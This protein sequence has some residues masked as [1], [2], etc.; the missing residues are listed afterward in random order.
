MKLSDSVRLSRKKFSTKRGRSIFAASTSALGIILIVVMLMATS[1]ILEFV[2]N[3]FRD[4]L[5]NQPLFIDSRML[6]REGEVPEPG[7]GEPFELNDLKT[8]FSNYNFKSSEKFLVIGGLHYGISAK[9]DS[10]SELI[11]RNP[12]TLLIS[13]EFFVKDFLYGDYKF[14]N[15]YG[16]KIPVV[17][18]KPYIIENE[19]DTNNLTQE[20]E[21]KNVQKTFDKYLGKTFKLTQVTVGDNIE[22]KEIS[23]IE[24]I[25]VGFSNSV[26]AF[27]PLSHTM[28]TSLTIPTWALESNSTINDLFKTP[29]AELNVIEM[30]SIEARDKFIEEFYGKL[31]E[32]FNRGNNVESFTF[33]ESYSPVRSRFFIVEEFLRIAS[34][35]GLVLGGFLLIISSLFTLTTIGKLVDDSKKEIGVFRAFGALKSDIRKIYYGYALLLINLGFVIGFVIA[36]IVNI[37]LS[38]A[39]GSRLFYS[40]I[41]LGNNFSVDSPALMFVSFPILPLIGLILAINILGILAAVLP[42]RRATKID[43]IIVMRDD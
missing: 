1:G 21:F 12:N 41:N 6:C 33:T 25:V 34:I 10:K 37:V 5:A 28:S 18:P 8:K 40:L 43:P 32:R 11:R 4:S 22:T 13:N 36:L 17:I 23:D 39:F 29:L 20:E 14:E 24:L 27:D 26:A 7:C 16:E 30:D 15:I 9:D 35:I 2:K 42:V 19:Y 31:I 38:L 3:N